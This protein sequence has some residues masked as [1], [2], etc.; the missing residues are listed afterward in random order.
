MDVG[1]IE[2]GFVII[3]CLRLYM[4]IFGMWV[5]EVITDTCEFG[6]SLLRIKYMFVQFTFIQTLGS[7]ASGTTSTRA[8]FFSEIHKAIS[9]R[10]TS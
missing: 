5:M 10:T 9:A 6:K 4:F 3:L 1:R 2:E 7:S 8:S